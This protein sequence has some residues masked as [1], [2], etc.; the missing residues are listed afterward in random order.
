MRWWVAITKGSQP[1]E[2]RKSWRAEVAVVAYSAKFSSGAEVAKGL[3]GQASGVTG[4]AVIIWGRVMVKRAFCLSG[5]MGAGCCQQFWWASLIL[6][7]K[8][9]TGSRV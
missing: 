5:E 7:E 6:I 4:V 9:S 1:S 3:S 8:E 2:K